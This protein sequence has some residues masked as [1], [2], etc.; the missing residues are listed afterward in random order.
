LAAHAGLPFR[1]GLVAPQAAQ[2]ETDVRPP[3]GSVVPSWSQRS[4]RGALA[5]RVAKVDERHLIL[6]LDFPTAEDADHVAREVWALLDSVPQGE[7]RELDVDASPHP[8]AGRM[9]PWTRERSSCSS[10]PS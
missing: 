6:I 9:V 4:T 5:A 8:G 7:S 2:T 10:A 3:S 1:V